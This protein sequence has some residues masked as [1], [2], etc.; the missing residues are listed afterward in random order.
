MNQQVETSIFLK[1]Y[2]WEK[3]QKYIFLIGLWNNI[4][5][6]GDSSVDAIIYG[7]CPLPP[8]CFPCKEEKEEIQALFD[9]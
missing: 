8:S 2:K 3:N 1:N 6:Q 9:S 7:S 4:S 5:I